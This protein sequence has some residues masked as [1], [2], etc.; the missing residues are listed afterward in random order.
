M[1]EIHSADIL[2]DKSHGVRA[3][4]GVVSAEEKLT[5]LM[6]AFPAP[7][8]DLA[9]ALPLFVMPHVV[10]RMMFFADLYRLVLDVPGVIME[11]GVRYGRDLATLIGLRT[12]YEPLNYSRKIIGFDT[13]TGFPSVDQKDGAVNDRAEGAFFIGEDY[14][15]YLAH[16]LGTLEA[17][18]P[19]DHLKKFEVAKGDASKT[20]PRYLSDHP[21]TIVALAYFDMDLY[22][23]TRDCLEA[24]QP[25]LTRGSVL[26]FDELNCQEFPGETEAVR[27][28]LGLDRV[29][30]RRFP[31]TNPG[32]PT[33]LV[34]E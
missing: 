11:F 28:V 10:R 8:R 34:V 19:Y 25:H 3:S 16:V 31:G 29:R 5:D 14:D 4:S 7:A 17:M 21:E 20:V 22:A 12:L 13:F 18:A 1:S 27:E 32:L 30:L 26:A 6:R 15:R 2:R 23:P 9:H 24:L 33:Y